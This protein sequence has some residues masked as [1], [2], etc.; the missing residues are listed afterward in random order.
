MGISRD[1]W[2]KR[3]ATGGKRCAPHK[4]RKFELGR[5]ASNTKKTVCLE[6]TIAALANYCS[7]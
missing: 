2:H 6:E 5:P 7:R 4:K 3:R 1:N